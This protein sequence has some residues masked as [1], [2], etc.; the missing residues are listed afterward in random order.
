[1]K[2]EAEPHLL[3]GFLRHGSGGETTLSPQVDDL[4]WP[5]GE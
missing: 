1:M 2:T 5:V 4:I 3:N